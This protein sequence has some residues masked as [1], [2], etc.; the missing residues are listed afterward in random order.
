MK[1]EAMKAKGHQQKTY[2]PAEL[3]KMYRIYDPREQRWTNFYDKFVRP[4]NR[5]GETK[6]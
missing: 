1:K 4:D 2:S 3:L 5:W 6:T